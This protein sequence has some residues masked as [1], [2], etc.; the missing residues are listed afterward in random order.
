MPQTW[1][2]AL[3]RY[4]YPV[5]LTCYEQA[6][7]FP[8]FFDRQIKGD[9]S[10][11]MD[12]EDYFR[13]TIQNIE[14]WY[15]VVFWKLGKQWRDNTTTEIIERFNVQ[16]AVTVQ[17]LTTHLKTF[18]DNPNKKNFNNFRELFGFR[19][20]SIAIVATFPAFSDPVRFPMV[21]A[22]VAKWVNAH[23][24]IHNAKNPKGLQLIK[25]RY[26]Q[27]QSTVLTMSDFNFYSCWINWTRYM[28]NK[29]SQLTNN[30]EWRARDVEMAVFTAWGGGKCSHPWLRL[31]AI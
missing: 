30:K 31:N 22:R 25:S 28:A 4:N 19:T 21:D 17:K 23:L 2:N 26:G 3:S 6:E 13:V 15:E 29:L 5:D 24:D 18:I 9:R 12:F 11:T 1:V 20:E 27:N 16:P 14:V 7:N 8:K 10:S